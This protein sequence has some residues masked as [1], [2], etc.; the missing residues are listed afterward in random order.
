MTELDPH[1]RKL[2]QHE[3]SQV[4]RDLRS[5]HHTADLSHEKTRVW[6]RPVTKAPAGHPHVRAA[7][8]ATELAVRAPVPSVRASSALNHPPSSAARA[9]PTGAMVQQAA[10]FQVEPV[11]TR[12]IPGLRSLWKTG[13][14]VVCGLALL[15][16]VLSQLRSTTPLQTR[17]L[18][19]QAA[20]VDKPIASAAQSAPRQVTL[21][22]KLL[23][24]SR[25]AAVE[26]L[27]SGRMSDAL[28]SYRALAQAHADEPAF[29]FVVAQLEWELRACKTDPGSCPR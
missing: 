27:I 7:E 25:S 15:G 29:A 9:Q 8:P 26:Q 28:D 4:L 5:S 23:P 2:T 22:S 6:R 1:T 21:P 10:G 24:P 13:F 3:I 12:D 17:A 19:P 14:L 11:A 18:P 20:K 16:A